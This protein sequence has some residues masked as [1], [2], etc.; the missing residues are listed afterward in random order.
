MNIIDDIVRLIRR[1]SPKQVGGEMKSPFLSA[2]GFTSVNA[3]D[4]LDSYKDRAETVGDIKAVLEH[5]DV[6]RNLEAVEQMAFSGW[7]IKAIP[8]EDYNG[9]DQKLADEEKEI[10]NRLWEFNKIW[11]IEKKIPQT[12]EAIRAYRWDVQEIYMGQIGKWQVPIYWEQLPPHSFGKS[13]SKYEGNSKFIPD[14]LLKGIIYDVEAKKHL[15]FQAQDSTSDPREI[16]TDNVFFMSDPHTNDP[17]GHSYFSGL[18]PYI[19]AQGLATMASNQTM[20]RG[21]TP[22]AIFKVKNLD[23]E[24]DLGFT[25]SEGDEEN[26]GTSQYKWWSYADSLAGRQGKDTRMVVPEEID[27]IWP[28]L[29]IALNPLD[30]E[31]HWKAKIVDAIVPVDPMKQL[32]TSLA[33]S[34]KEL[35]DYLEGIFGG[36]REQVGAYAEVLTYVV[37]INGWEGWTIESTF[38][39]LSPKDIKQEKD[40]SLRSYQAG[41]IPVSRYYE[42]TGRP[43]LDPAEQLQLY[44]EILIRAGK[45]DQLPLLTP[46]L[47]GLKIVGQSAEEEPLP[48]EQKGLQVMLQAKSDGL[49]SILADEGYFRTNDE[50]KEHNK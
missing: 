5:L 30:A 23:K 48:G 46:E 44:R 20:A 39:P 34:S 7:G 50:H 14:R 11:Q 29:K 8:P 33:K 9:N 15:F 19:K 47:V 16:P 35:L 38:T 40:H 31:D 18:V 1:P 3:S 45:V 22:N 36:Y 37:N 25:V 42:E 43:A 12:F 26:I 2:V 28:D 41:A 17:Q 6:R 27:V 49:L 13:L 24:D 4:I 32:G 10:I 21:G